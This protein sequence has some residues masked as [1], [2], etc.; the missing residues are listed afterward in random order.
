MLSLRLRR[1]T[2]Y[3]TENRLCILSDTTEFLPF[4][5]TVYVYPAPFRRIIDRDAVASAAPSQRKKTILP[6]PEQLRRMLL[7]QQPVLPAHRRIV[8]LYSSHH[9]PYSITR[10]DREN[11]ATHR[12]SRP[13]KPHEPDA[14]SPAGHTTRLRNL[15]RPGPG[16]FR[17][18][19]ALRKEINITFVPAQVP[20]AAV[21][22]REGI[23]REC[24]ENR[25]QFPLL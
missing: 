8:I 11:T 1:G 15:R 13:R 20:H 4:R 21:H 7:L 12:R 5:R 16:I 22:A 2:S 25:Q 24:R 3:H 9:P 6:A 10:K 23:K 18:R 19:A 17:T 14:C